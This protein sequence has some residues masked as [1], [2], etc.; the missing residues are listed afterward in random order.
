MS[1]PAGFYRE[2]AISFESA[3]LH[4]LLGATRRARSNMKE[5]KYM[6][7]FPIWENGIKIK[8]IGYLGK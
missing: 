5:C 6:I 7:W 8:S 1:K 2:I 3:K 4:G